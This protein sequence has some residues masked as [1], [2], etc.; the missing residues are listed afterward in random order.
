MIGRLDG[1][2]ASKLPPHLLVNVSGVHYEIAA[3]MS[4]FYQLPEIG[5]TCSLH[6]HLVVRDDAHLL[7]GF[8]TTEERH[9]FRSLIKVNG[10][11]PKLALTIL[12]GIEPDDFVASIQNN[13]SSRLVNIPGIGKKTAERLLIETRDTLKSWDFSTDATTASSTGQLKADAISALTSLGYKTTDATRA[14]DALDESPNSSE[15]MIRLAL[16]HMMN[17]VGA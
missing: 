7:Y 9:L 3:P 10:V 2:L 8:A 13:D 14:I 17:R 16:K 15:D 5:N 6:T 12:S 1:I 4:T 11:G